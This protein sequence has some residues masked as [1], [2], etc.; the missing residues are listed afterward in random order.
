MRRDPDGNGPPMR[1]ASRNQ[2]SVTRLGLMLV[3]TAGLALTSP[4]PLIAVVFSSMTLVG[5]MII[6]AFALLRSEKVHAPHFTRWDEAAALFAMSLLSG[7]F[8]DAAA[9]DALMQQNTGQ[10]AAETAATGTP[11]PPA[12]E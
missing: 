9:V 5:A 1:N 7:Q 4:Q 6:G 3:M 2:Q 12:G 11:T 8:I 10:E